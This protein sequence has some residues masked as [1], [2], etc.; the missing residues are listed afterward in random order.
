[1][2]PLFKVGHWLKIDGKCELD[3]VSGTLISIKAFCHSCML[4]FMCIFVHVHHC[5]CV[6]VYERGERH[7]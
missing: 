1:M 4:V 7:K 6:C 5:V 3:V 2:E